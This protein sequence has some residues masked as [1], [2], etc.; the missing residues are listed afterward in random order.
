MLAAVGV[1]LTAEE[2]IK[3]ILD[4][5]PKEYDPFITSHLDP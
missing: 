3:T 4:S 1:S 5:L 2:H